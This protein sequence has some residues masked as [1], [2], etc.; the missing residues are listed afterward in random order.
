MEGGMVKGNEKGYL[1]ETLRR[2]QITH[3]ATQNAS[4]RLWLCDMPSKDKDQSLKQKTLL[5]FL[6]KQPGESN[7]KASSAKPAE[8]S[9]KLAESR[10]A[11]LNAT[12]A[13]KSARKSTKGHNTPSSGPADVSQFTSS[14]SK[15]AHSS[16]LTSPPDVTMISDDEDD[17]EVVLSSKVVSTS[18]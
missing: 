8:A 5:G 2:K 1:I 10:G 4:T 17:Q 6:S 3:D 7:P 12:P 13:S 11:K 14:G 16:P 15:N 9:S 18:F